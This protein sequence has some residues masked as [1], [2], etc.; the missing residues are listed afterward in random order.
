M[1]AEE[2]VYGNSKEIIWNLMILV[3]FPLQFSLAHALEQKHL[4]LEKDGELKVSN[5][6]IHR[7]GPRLCH[8]ICN[9]FSVCPEIG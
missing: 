6:W 7:R 5:S 1:G 8:G 3:F 2:N 4:F 9:G